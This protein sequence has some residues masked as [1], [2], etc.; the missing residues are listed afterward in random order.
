MSTVKIGPENEG[1][2]KISNSGFWIIK[3]TLEQVINEGSGTVILDACHFSD[4]DIPNKGAA[5]IKASNGRL[6]VSNCEFDR[7]WTGN[8]YEK[9]RAVLLEKDCISAVITG[10]LFH[11]DSIDNQSNAQLANS[12]NIFENK[13]P[14]IDM[15]ELTLND[16][17]K[18]YELNVADIIKIIK[19]KGIE[20]K[21]EM[22]IEEI[23]KENNISPI[24]LYNTVSGALKDMD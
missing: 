8:I 6:I 21:P 17:C 5:C 18:M 19:S 22:T 24:D 1:Q 12:A 2:V 23:A 7:P 3:E 15:S 14:E 11:N 10:C 16:F 4:W 9:K 20:A 13:K